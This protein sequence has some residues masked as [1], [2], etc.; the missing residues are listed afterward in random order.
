IPF[1]GHHPVK[2][3]ISLKPLGGAPVPPLTAKSPIT[4]KTVKRSLATFRD[5]FCDHCLGACPN[6]L[7]KPYFFIINICVL[8]LLCSSFAV[9]QE[10]S[11]ALCFRS[12]CPS[13]QAADLTAEGYGQ[14]G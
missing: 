11:S 12:L 8:F 7:K 5:I 14:P 13:P 1:K 4:P 6:G 9:I 2:T 10:H 3:S